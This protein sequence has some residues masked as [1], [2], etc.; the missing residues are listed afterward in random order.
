MRELISSSPFTYGAA[1]FQVVEEIVNGSTTVHIYNVP[2]RNVAAEFIT[3]GADKLFLKSGNEG[4]NMTGEEFMALLNYAKSKHSEIQTVSQD[5]R[6][7]VLQSKFLQ[8]KYGGYQEISFFRL[9]ALL[10]QAN[11][12]V[13]IVMYMPTQIT[14]NDDRN[15][16]ERILKDLKALGYEI[17]ENHENFEKKPLA[18]KQAWQAYVTSYTETYRAQKHL[19]ET[20]IQLREKGFLP[21]YLRSGFEE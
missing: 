11:G 21:E 6:R 17:L 5:T 16:K 18:L 14:K 15:E 4:E 20:A 1:K 10:E 19:V 2:G 3:D 8:E 7:P 13:Q 12:S 9:H